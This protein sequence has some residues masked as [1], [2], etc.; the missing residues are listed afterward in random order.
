[1][2]DTSIKIKAKLKIY[3]KRNFK[4]ADKIKKMEGNETLS[5]S[6]MR[7]HILVR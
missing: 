6:I 7:F 4:V 2:M 3:F 5:M 1:M